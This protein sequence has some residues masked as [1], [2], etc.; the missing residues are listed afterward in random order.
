M[1]NCT[2]CLVLHERQLHGRA[3]SSQH[4]TR[5]RSLARRF[6]ASLQR[7]AARRAVGTERPRAGELPVR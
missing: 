1:F 6:R 2:I 5:G 4:P 3:S 7:D